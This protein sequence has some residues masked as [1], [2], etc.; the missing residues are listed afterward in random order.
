MKN[1]ENS[2]VI[3]EDR[4]ADFECEPRTSS[5]KINF[6]DKK[7]FFTFDYDIQKLSH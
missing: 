6:Y 1:C 3:I 5:K 7:V 2:N 4:L